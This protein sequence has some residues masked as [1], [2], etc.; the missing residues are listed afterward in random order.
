MKNTEIKKLV[1]DVLMTY[2]NTR[3]CDYDLYKSILWV[4][5]HGQTDAKTLLNLMKDRKIP[6]FESVSRARRQL[7]QHEE[8][9]RGELWEKRQ[10]K[11][12][13]QRKEELGYNSVKLKL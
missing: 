5:G 13:D 11:L 3:D 8:H 9:L 4:Y 2:R 1:K 12:Q 7:Q 6:S 10:G